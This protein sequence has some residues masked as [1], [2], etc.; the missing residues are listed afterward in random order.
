MRRA[1][2]AAAAQNGLQRSRRG[3]GAGRLPTVKMAAL[4]PKSREAA[5][6]PRPVARGNGGPC[7]WE[8]ARASVQPVRDLRRAVIFALPPFSDLGICGAAAAPQLGARGGRG[9]APCDPWGGG[10]RGRCDA[11]ARLLRSQPCCGQWGYSRAGGCSSAT[12]NRRA[13]AAGDPLRA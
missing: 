10:L 5:R 1:E 12:A 13:A 7:A 2:I 11:R 6:P 4:P 3:G 9:R 8:G